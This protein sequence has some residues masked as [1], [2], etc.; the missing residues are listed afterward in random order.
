MSILATL[1]FWLILAIVAILLIA[2]LRTRQLASQA[3][4]TLPQAGD[5]IPVQGGTIHYVDLGPRDGKPL[6]M[7]HGLS[8]QLQHY[9]YALADLLADDYRLIILD[10]P[11]C[12]YSTR[13]SDDLAAIPEQARM[14]WEFLDKLEI[15]NPVLVGHSLGGAISLA[16]ALQ[17][18][19]AVAALALLCPAT[20][21]QTETPA[22]FKGIEVRSAFLRRLLGNT[23]AVPIA[24]ATAAKVLGEVFKPEPVPDGFMDNAGG[25]LG[26]RPSAFV[27][28]ASD[29]VTFE[30]T[31]GE[32]EARYASELSVP[33]GVLYGA[34]DA[35]L[36]PT[37]HG[38]PMTA[39]GLGYRELPGRGHM[40]PITAAQDCADFIR[41]VAG[42][43]A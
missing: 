17:R 23:I 7:I 37:A 33:G 2:H 20:H 18:K 6:V 24:K 10:R 12:G 9:T 34:D 39:F 40:I 26:L 1:L 15:N 31:M 29:L 5:V 3:E 22:V 35:V 8:G 14:I 4:K 25:V 11:G 21:L 43:G 41:E 28:A 38:Q 30:L 27:T 19:D 16:M 36:S 42:K 32:Q 13:N